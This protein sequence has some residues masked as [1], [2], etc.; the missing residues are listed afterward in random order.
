MSV[1]HVGILA[2]QG[3]E[4]LS[5]GHGKMLTGKCAQR[6]VPA[7]GANDF[8]PVTLRREYPMMQGRS[9]R[10]PAIHGIAGGL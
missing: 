1:E 9:G 3:E 6:A 4:R 5:V 10:D 7:G 2:G 8:H